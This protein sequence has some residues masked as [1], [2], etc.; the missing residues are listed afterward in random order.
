[1]RLHLRDPGRRAA[2]GDTSFYI[3]GLFVKLYAYKPKP[4]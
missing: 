1:M 4:V 2:Q 3:N